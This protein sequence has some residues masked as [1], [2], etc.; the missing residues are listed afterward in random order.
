LLR[1]FRK[2]LY[3]LNVVAL[4]CRWRVWRQEASE[5]RRSRQRKGKAKERTWY[6]Q[7]G[8]NTE[9]KAKV[10]NESNRSRHVWWVRWMERYSFLKS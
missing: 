1:I 8:P 6:C 5:A 7:T 9:R 4:I 3:S 10:R 2:W